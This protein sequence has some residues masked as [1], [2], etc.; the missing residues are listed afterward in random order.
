MSQTFARISERGTNKL[1]EPTSIAFT[2]SSDLVVIASDKVFCFNAESY[3]FVKYV[4]NKYLK[5][6]HC[7]TIEPNGR[8]V[9]CDE[10]DLTVKVLSSVGSRLLHTINDP[11]WANP[12]FALSSEDDFRFLFSGKR[13]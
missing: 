8:M 3:K 2:K 4:T 1:T 13:C 9:V 10:G 6:P 5:T 7:L 12:R 11:G